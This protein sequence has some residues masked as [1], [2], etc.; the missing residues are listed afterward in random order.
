MF[1]REIM[2]VPLGSMGDAFVYSPIIHHYSKFH[3]CIHVPTLSW[4]IPTILT[5]FQ[6]NPK[7]KVFEYYEDAYVK[8]YAQAH[9]LIEL[10]HPKLVFIPY[11]GTRSCVLWDEQLYTFYD[12]P[13]SLRY[14]G[15]Q[16]PKN[17]PRSHLL[18]NTIVK[19]P[20]Y[21]LT[22]AHI[23]TC[24]EKLHLDLA[25]WRE[26]MGLPSLDQFQIIDLTP[27]LTNNMLDYVDLIQNA[28]EIHCVPSSVQCL[29]DSLAYKI[30]ARLFWHDR[31]KDTLM[32]I[33]NNWNNHK[34][35]VIHYEEKF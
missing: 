15:F 30:H 5:L 35:Q 6:E 9:D 24:A 32:R 2:A 13:F 28:S 27:N 1:N 33:N 22:H 31:R 26:G 3:K 16:I 8:E 7:V 21:I 4:M 34:W 29:V 20:Q 17:L 11:N 12:L 10:E 14:E 23:G 25:S 18:Y 19:N